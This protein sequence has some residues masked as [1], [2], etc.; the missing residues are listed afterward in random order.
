[1]MVHQFHKQETRASNIITICDILW[2]ELPESYSDKVLI[3]TAMP[4]I[5]TLASIMEVWHKQRISYK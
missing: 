5:T 1:M 4:C 2:N 3:T